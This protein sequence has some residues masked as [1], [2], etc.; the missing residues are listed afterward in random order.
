M[1]YYIS[2]VKRRDPAAPA[3][4]EPLDELAE[5]LLA[6][7]TPAEVRAFLDDLW[8]AGLNRLKKVA[9]EQA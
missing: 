1:R 7:R 2:A 6:L 8:S 3:G 4:P 9:E 5:A